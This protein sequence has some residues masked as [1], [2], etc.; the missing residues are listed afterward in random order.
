MLHLKNKVGP[1]KSIPRGFGIQNKEDIP[2]IIKYYNYVKFHSNRFYYLNCSTDE[3]SML[4]CTKR[5]L[6]Q[7]NGIDHDVFF[8]FNMHPKGMTKD[9][10]AALKKYHK[11]LIGYYGKNIQ[12]LRFQDAAEIVGK[13]VN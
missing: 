11:S 10:F 7:F 4:K 12:A 9:H 3:K 6:Q 2:R 1:V 13:K 8:S 5:Y